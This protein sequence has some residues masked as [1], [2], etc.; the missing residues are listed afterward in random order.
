MR[1]TN[2]LQTD[3]FLHYLFLSIGM[4]AVLLALTGLQGCAAK[5]EKGSEIREVDVLAE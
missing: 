2:I 4:M 5:D 3:F 1:R